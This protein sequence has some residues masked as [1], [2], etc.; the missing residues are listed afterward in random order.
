MPEDI[1]KYEESE[2]SVKSQITIP[3]SLLVTL[4]ALA[5]FV[6][7]AA[8]APATIP[9]SN[10]KA[11]APGDPQQASRNAVATASAGPAVN[12]D[13]ADKLKRPPIKI[14][15]LVMLSGP[16]AM[17]GAMESDAIALAIEDINNSGGIN[18]SPLEIVRYDTRADPQEAVTQFRKLV[19]QDGVVAVLGP[20]NSG[21]FEVVAPLAVETG[22]AAMS[23][24]GSP[25][26]AAA[27]RPFAFQIH[28]PF[29]SLAA[30]TVDAFVKKYPEVKS[31]ALAG[32]TK[33][34]ASEAE[35]KRIYP[36]VFTERGLRLAG[37]VEFDTATTDYSAIVT[38]IKDLDPDAL[39]ASGIPGPAFGL[40]KEMERQGFRKRLLLSGMLGGGGSVIPLMGSYLDGTVISYWVDFEDKSTQDWQSRWLSVVK[41]DARVAQKPLFASTDLSVYNA[42]MAMA[43]TMREARIGAE[44]PLKEVRSKIK[45]GLERLRDFQGVGPR[46]T[47][48]P[49]GEWTWK[50]IPLIVQGGQAFVAK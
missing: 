28:V 14:G 1:R 42:T 11:G 35:I 29:A 46:I 40:L 16:L 21:E 15:H 2:K 5:V 7:L 6:I 47:A 37:T 25:G 33:Y 20:F 34:R 17:Y 24:A 44:T 18:W 12:A 19:D 39:F 38:R 10:S 26:I 8:C 22:V 4:A 9:A 27:N 23:I 49:S 3:K 41:A 45:D 36:Q 43:G 31:V 50:A 30:P 48:L 32:D 13:P